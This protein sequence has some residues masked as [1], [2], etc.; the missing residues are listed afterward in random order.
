MEKRHQQY[1]EDS[2]R[3][4]N[5]LNSICSRLLDADARHERISIA[6]EIAKRYKKTLEK[7]DFRVKKEIAQTLIN[8]IVIH[9][10]DVDVDFVFQKPKKRRRKDSKKGPTGDSN[11]SNPYGVTGRD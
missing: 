9:K 10:K 5:Q 2:A 11:Q 4:Q 3:V 1:L 8:R 7:M 6:K